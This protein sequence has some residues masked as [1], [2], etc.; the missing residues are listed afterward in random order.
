MK[1]I[2]DL[3][4][5]GGFKRGDLFIIGVGPSRIAGSSF[6]AHGQG[7]TLQLE[8]CQK[9]VVRTMAYLNVLEIKPR[10]H[11]KRRNQ[12]EAY[13]RKIQ[14]RWDKRAK[15]ELS[16]QEHESKVLSIKPSTIVKVKESPWAV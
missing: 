7:D 12:T 2:Y 16:F 14:K 4:K 9:D 11:K 15:K 13:H 3:V 10:Q 5:E 8:M 6:F 1:T